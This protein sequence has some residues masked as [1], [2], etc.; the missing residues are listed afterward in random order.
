MAPVQLNPYLNLDGTTKEALEFYRQVFGE[1]YLQTYGESPMETP[2]EQK[3]RI[4]HGRLDADGITIMAADSPHDPPV[5][6]DNV[7]LSLMGPDGARLTD[8]F[9]GLA[10]GGEVTMPLAEQFWGDTFGMLTDRFG[11]HWMIN[12]TK[13]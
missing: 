3:D 5:S 7:N 6:G 1:L 2:E 11:I 4:M 12:V 8:V 9:N 10:Q 13:A